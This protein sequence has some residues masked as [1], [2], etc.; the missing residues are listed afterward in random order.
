M[1]TRRGRP[2]KR[3][4]P[5]V[6]WLFVELLR[7]TPGNRRLSAR[8]AAH[9]LEKELGKTFVGGRVL[10]PWETIRRL[11]GKFVRAMAKHGQLKIAAIEL[12]EMHRQRREALGW[13]IPA[14]EWVF[15]PADFQLLGG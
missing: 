15:D 8:R 14:W 2:P 13:D 9:R 5:L 4:V 3:S 10:L 11:H 12:L 1:K 7:D 6:A